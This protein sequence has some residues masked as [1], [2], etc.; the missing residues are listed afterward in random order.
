MSAGPSN[1]DALRD[2]PTIAGRVSRLPAD[3]RERVSLSAPVSRTLSGWGRGHRSAVANKHIQARH[4][5]TKHSR[6]K[7][8][9]GATAG[10]E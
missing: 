9:H 7:R 8:L 2:S 4:G 5:S 3:G 6:G 10:G 1:Q